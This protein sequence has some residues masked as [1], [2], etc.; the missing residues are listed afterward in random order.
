MSATA[1]E[2]PEYIYTNIQVKAAEKDAFMIIIFILPSL[3]FLF[4]YDGI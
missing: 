3:S 2:A 1:N 4:T